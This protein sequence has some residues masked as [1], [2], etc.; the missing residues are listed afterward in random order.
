MA[1]QGGLGPKQAYKSGAGDMEEKVENGSNG[2]HG[3]TAA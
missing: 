3:E 1:A 2:Y